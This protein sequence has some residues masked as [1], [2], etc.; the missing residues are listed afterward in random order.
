MTSHDRLTYP[1]STL[2]PSSTQSQRVSWNIPFL[3]NNGPS[4]DDPPRANTVPVSFNP[5]RRTFTSPA[6][7]SSSKRDS[8]SFLPPT[9]IPARDRPQSTLTLDTSRSSLTIPPSLSTFSDAHLLTPI[10]SEDGRSLSPT[11]SYEEESSFSLSAYMNRTR[12]DAEGGEVNREEAPTPVLKSYPANATSPLDTSNPLFSRIRRIP[13]P[14][15]PLQPISPRPFTPTTPSSSHSSTTTPRPHPHTNVNVNYS[16][17]H[18]YEPLRDSDSVN[19]EVLLLKPILKNA[20]RGR[21]RSASTSAE[22]PANLSFLRDLCVELWIDQVGIA[23]LSMR[24]KG[25]VLTMPC[26]KDSEL[27]DLNSSST[28]TALRVNLPT[29]TRIQT[30]EE[31]K[32]FTSISQLQ[33]LA[34]ESVNHGIFIMRCAAFNANTNGWLTLMDTHAGTRLTPDPPPSNPLRRRHSR[35]HLSSSV[36]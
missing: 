35:F 17:P 29:K 23:L 12:G 4:S 5:F 26:R 27:Y 20:G 22:L 9:H 18:P 19:S 7:P 8:V 28:D 13:P 2:S 3:H 1:S 15:P 10:D 24:L 33:S 25:V 6:D 16:R 11:D 14:Q 21:E 31:G 36:P 30:R 32:T 34:L